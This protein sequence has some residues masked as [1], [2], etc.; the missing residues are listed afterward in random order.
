VT[1]VQTCALPISAIRRSPRRSRR[2]TL[3]EHA[4]TLLPFDRYKLHSI[5]RNVFNMLR[6][7]RRDKIII[8]KLRIGHTYLMHG[9]LG[10]LRGETPPR[11]LA[12]QVDLT[13]EH[14]LLHRVSFTSARD[15]FFLCYFDFN[16]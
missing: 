12:C 10:L 13:V 4:R 11:C 3:C 15:D 6:S 2:R 7:P 16:V 8:H 9:H 14:V 1:G 5:E